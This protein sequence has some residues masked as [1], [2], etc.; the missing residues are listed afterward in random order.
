MGIEELGVEVCGVDVSVDGPIHD[1]GFL[2]VSP[3]DEPAVCHDE[4]IVEPYPGA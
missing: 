4:C 1:C 2:G 3:E